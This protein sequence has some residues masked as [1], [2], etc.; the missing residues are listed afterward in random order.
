M[1]S[2][3]AIE[4]AR[5]MIEDLYESC[6]ESTIDYIRDYEDEE[7]VEYVDEEEADLRIE[8]CNLLLDAR[9]YIES[10]QGILHV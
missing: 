6:G 9:D 3:A 5:Q 4:I 8:I 10:Y 2:K 7:S 1:P